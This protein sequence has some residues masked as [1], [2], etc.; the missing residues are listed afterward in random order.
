MKRAQ[1]HADQ[2]DGPY[3]GGGFFQKF[4]GAL[5]DFRAVD[6]G[7]LPRNSPGDGLEIRVFY[8]QRDVE[9]RVPFASGPPGHLPR[10]SADHDPQFP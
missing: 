1:S 8:L 6:K 9:A 4:R 5:A 7:P 2:A 3:S 10:Q